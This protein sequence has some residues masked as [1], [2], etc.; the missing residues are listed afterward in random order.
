MA[1]QTVGILVFDEV[2]ILDFC[3]PFEV[4]SSA[5]AAGSVGRDANRLYS[6]FTI[7]ETLDVV[8]CRGGLLVQP[9]FAISDHPPIDILVVPGG[10][11]T[12]R[13][14][15][16]PRLL[17]WIRAVDQ[18]AAL[19]TS[20]CTGA[21]VLAKTGRLDGLRVTTHWGAIASLRDDYPAL[22]VI[23]DERVIDQGRII[24]SAGVSAGIDM[25]LYVV[26]KQH[27]R[28]VAEETARGM[29][30]DWRG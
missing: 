5:V 10:Y 13:V 14:V 28:A 18:S 9:S 8:R 22:E 30:Y 15:Q 7:A 4:F 24:T 19:T 21:F 27:G 17:D 23:D 16:N 3:G 12:D 11:G 2:E 25:A 1:Q 20:V 6:A 29:E 26:E